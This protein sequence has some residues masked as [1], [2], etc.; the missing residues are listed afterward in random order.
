MVEYYHHEQHS[1]PK[2]A[3]R[4]FQRLV[5]RSYPKLHANLELDFPDTED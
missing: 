3:W 1:D 4:E 5:Q 2:R